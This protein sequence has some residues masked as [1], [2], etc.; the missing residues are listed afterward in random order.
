MKKIEA[1]FYFSLGTLDWITLEDVKYLFSLHSDIEFFHSYCE[2]RYSI[3]QLLHRFYV[4]LSYKR[5]TKTYSPYYMTE[6]EVVEIFN[7]TT[8]FDK[9][10][11]YRN[12]KLSFGAFISTFQLD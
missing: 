5:N 10:Y 6:N 7:K 3:S 8:S 12:P 9:N 2:K 11:I 4:Y 1:D